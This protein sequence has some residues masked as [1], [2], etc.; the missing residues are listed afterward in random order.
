MMR[1]TKIAAAITL[2]AGLLVGCN[3]PELVQEPEVTPPAPTSPLTGAYWDIS[4]SGSAAA[5]ASATDLPNVYVFDGT[6]QKYYDDDATPGTYKIY[7]TTYTENLDDDTIEFTYYS[8]DGPTVVNGSYSVSNGTLLTITDTSYGDLSGSD[9][10]QNDDV[11]DAVQA[12]NDELGL[13]NAVQ[14]L[15]TTGST[16]DPEFKGDTGKL[17]LQLEDPAAITSGKITVDLVYE[18]D[19]NTEQEA[20]G[21]G[22]SA[23]ISLYAGGTSNSNLHGEIILTSSGSIKF[24]DASGTQVDTGG[25]FK[26]GENL[27]V[28]ASWADDSFTFS[29]NGVSYDGQVSENAPVQIISLKLGDNGNTTNYRLVADNLK[30]YSNDVEADTLVFEDDFESYLVGSSLSDNLNYADSSEATVI[31]TNDDTTEPGDVTDDFESYDIGES[32]DVASQNLWSVSNIVSDS[33]GSTSAVVSKGPLADDSQTLFLTDASSDTKPFAMRSFSG[34]AATGS[35]SLDVYTPETNE[36]ATY[37]HLGVGKNNS[38]RYFEVKLS[39][40][41]LNYSTSSEG[42]QKITDAAQG[43]WH[44][45]TVDWSN[46]LIDVSLNGSKVATGISQA[47]TGFSASNIPTQLTLYTGDNSNMTNTAYFDNVD[48]DLF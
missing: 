14:I 11:K 8:A 20:D 44:A 16:I 24:R 30:V 27:A 32:I 13:N 36:K 41:N 4:D 40:G 19:E 28:E 34:A 33:N 5:T 23:Y 38:D 10:A 18:V 37:I 26:E 45:L 29:I 3:G 31:G 25:T 47:D 39:G 7:T 21:S 43:Q 42:D 12:A 35:V 6:D 46:G 48:S 17:R 9:Q 2:S 1:M 22:D 15:D